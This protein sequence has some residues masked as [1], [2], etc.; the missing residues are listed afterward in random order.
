MYFSKTAGNGNCE[1]KEISKDGLNPQGLFR[2]AWKA[3][4][5]V[6]ANVTQSKI[7]FSLEKRKHMV[8]TETVYLLQRYSLQ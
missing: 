7:V 5:Y 6:E 1:N 8:E 3:I 4:F 2:A